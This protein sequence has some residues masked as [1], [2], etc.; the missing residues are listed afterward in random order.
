MKLRIYE[1]LNERGIKKGYV[2]NKLGVSF[3]TLQR[4]NDDETEIPLIK[5]IQLAKILDCDINDLW[6]E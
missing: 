6:E 2:T 5:A 4:W 3:K 1:L